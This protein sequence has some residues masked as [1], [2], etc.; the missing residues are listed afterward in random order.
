MKTNQIVVVDLDGTLTLTDTLYESILALVRKKPHFL[1]LLP[2]WLLKGIAFLKLKVSENHAL[3]ITTLPYNLPLINWIRELKSCGK[4]IVLCTAANKLIALAVSEHLNLFDDVISSDGNTNLKGTNKRKILEKR[5]GYKGFDYA[6]NNE[7]DL[8]VWSSA[9]NAIV[10]NASTMLQ[11]KASKI[12]TVSKTFTSEGVKFLDWIRALRVYQW[13]KNLLLFVPVLAAHQLDNV[14]SLKILML[15]FLSFSLC[16]SSVYI[17]NDLLDIESDREHPRKRHRP[18]A[19][20]KL[21]IKAG[22]VIIPLLIGLSILLGLMV[23]SEFLSILI[24]Y[25]I[26]TITYSLVLKRF[27]LVDCITLATFY[28]IRIIAGAVALSLSVSFWLLAFS[29]FIFFSLALLKRYAELMIQAQ[30]RKNIAHGRGY[31]VSDASLLQ[32]FGVSS[33]YMSTLVI[34]LYVQSKEVIVLY[35]N[36]TMIWF[37]IPVILFW[38]SWVW[39]KAARAKMYDDPIIFAIKDKTSLIV[40]GLTVFILFFATAGMKI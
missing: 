26:L 14:Q 9:C 11:K 28:T 32:I 23:G 13:I 4:K 17:T 33:G 25:L 1:F 2:F 22:L 20:A 39:L 18:F 35:A 31:E 5:F 8:E 10:V 29:V 3:N 27:V 34:A 40:V 6:G 16:A 19:S 36:P 12:A 37:M 21:S 7:T 38:V 24:I 30:A 15:A